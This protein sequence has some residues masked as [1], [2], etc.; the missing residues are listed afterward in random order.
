MHFLKKILFKRVS[1]P[2]TKRVSTPK[3]N[4][5]KPSL[6]QNPA[7][8]VIDVGIEMANIIREANAKEALKTTSKGSS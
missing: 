4:W 7:L 2:K 6:S 3:T 5:S 8:Q 1:T